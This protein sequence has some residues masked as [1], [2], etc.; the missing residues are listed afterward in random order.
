M[1]EKAKKLSKENI[2]VDG[3]IDLP[4]RLYKENLLE[5]ENINLNKNTSGNFDTY[6]AK[7][8]GLNC[9]FMAIYTPS[10]KS[11]N[12]S[13]TFANSL[14]DLVNNVIKSNKE[15][16][17]AF[18]PKDVIKNFKKNKISL[19]MGMEN[20]SPIGEDINRIKY[21]FDR[22]IRYMTLTH[23]AD[24]QICDSSYDSRNTWNGLSN[25]GRKVVR[26]MNKI[27]MMIDVSHCTD[28]TFY[29][30]LK[31][32]NK[33]LVA[34]HSS[35]RK[36]TPNFERNMSDNMIKDLA[37][38]NG[39]IMLNFGSGFISEQ[40][41]KSLGDINSK[42]EKYKIENNLEDSDKKLLKY[43]DD[44]INTAKPFASINDFIDTIDHVKEL[45]GIDHIG[46]GSDFEGLG[47]TL[48]YDL[49]DASTY[50]NILYNLLEREYSEIEIKKICSD[51]LFRVWNANLQ[52]RQI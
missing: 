13:Y 8:G 38:N 15:F 24:N 37:N 41:N 19:P 31:I 34:T 3:H 29:D 50:P 32:T 47:N 17:Y 36:F 44:L 22:G 43:K 6:K 25:F 30:I 20:G 4:F 28:K 26:E 51:N 45:V 27:G 1:N 48:P 2:I 23:A 46:L 40:S 39:L 10:E 52:N 16:D 35:P 49:K 33:P 21:F 14:I 12:E 9:P 7:K 5:E 11:E 42:V 18:T